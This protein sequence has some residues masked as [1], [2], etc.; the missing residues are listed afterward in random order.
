[1]KKSS[2]FLITLFLLAGCGIFGVHFHIHNPRRAGKFPKKTEARVLLGN[3]D[4]KFR[5]CY[6]VKWYNL[7]VVFDNSGKKFGDK[8][9]IQVLT[10]MTFEAL[11]DFDTMQID[12]A[13]NMELYALSLKDQNG[14]EV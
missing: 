10:E 8:K 12:L 5:T 13:E 7:S 2:I 1:M 14:I 9:D 4:S 6:D 3:Q 11:A